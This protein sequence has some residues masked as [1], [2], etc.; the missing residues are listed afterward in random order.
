MKK[1]K[2]L[3]LLISLFVCCGQLSKA[4]TK[5]GIFFEKTTDLDDDEQAAYDW[6]VSDEY[7]PGHGLEKVVFTT[8]NINSLSASDVKVLW[9]PINRQGDKIDVVK[10]KVTSV[11][12]K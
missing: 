1:F 12:D 2:F 4:Q 11:W 8:D 3:F 5:V 10:P 7:N 9:I 6:F